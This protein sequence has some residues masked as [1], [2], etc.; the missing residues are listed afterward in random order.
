MTVA[1]E[2]R[3]DITADRT[4]FDATMEGMAQKAMTESQRMQSA[5]RDAF[6]QIGTAAGES[7]KK[8]NS[9]FDSLVEG[10]KKIRGALAAMGALLAGGSMFG[11]AI[12]QTAEL[13]GETRKLSTMLGITLEAASALRIALG[14]IG[15][16]TDDYTG[17]VAKMTMK[18]REN[19]DRFNELG[20]KTRDANG[21]LLNTELITTNALG[22]LK[23]FREGTDRN[24]ASTELFGRGWDGVNKL[25]KLTP[26]VMEEARQKAVSLELQIG[27]AGAERARQYKLA[28]NEIKDVGEALANRIGQALMPV[29]TDLGNWLASMGPAAVTVMRGAL[30]G[31]LTVVYAV[32]NG[33]VVMVRL[34]S[35]ALYTVIEPLAAMAEAAALTLTGHFAEAG[36]RLKQIPQNIS[37]RWKME[38]D[39][40]LKSGDLTRE[41]IAALFD[42]GAEQ[43]ATK[44]GGK[45]GRAY[46]PGAKAGAA[47][48]DAP[49]DKS[50]MGQW[51][52]DLAAQRD[53]YDKQ[54]L[55]QGSFQQFTLAMER[56]Y[57]KN[58][59][60]TVAM[61]DDERAAVSKKY[62][63]AERDLRKMAFDAEIAELKERL[64]RYKQGSI[65]RIRLAG[66]SAAMIG[67]KFGLESRE[68]KQ[69]LGEMS[70][71]AEERGKQQ[72]QLDA[73]MLGRTR[74][75]KVS[76]IELER[77]ALD[78]AEKLGI[79]SNRNK[80]L[81]LK[82]L[83]DIEYQIELQALTDTAALY[84]MDAVAY[85][86]HLDKLA[87]LKGKYALDAQ[88]LDGQVTAESKKTFDALFDPIGNGFQ[89]LM[90]GMIQGTQTW[91]EAIR[92]TLLAVGAEYLSAGVKIAVAWVKTEL[93]KTQATVAGVAVRGAAEK[94][95][96]A[97]SVLVS[98]WTAIK[99]IAIKAWEAAASVY[100]SI[101][102]IPYVGPFLA[103]VMAV[104]AA[105][106][107]LAFVGK[108]ASAEGGFD[109]PRGLSPITQLHPEEMTLPASIANPLRAA[110]EAGNLGVPN[111][112][113]ES[114]IRGIP[115]DEWLMIHRGDLV[116]ALRAAH[117]DFTFTKF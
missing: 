2:F 64:E 91:S 44:P 32:Q 55:E 39:E 101:A 93:L 60:D 19:E 6:T 37:A 105:G 110:I 71:M 77:Q 26:A 65:E 36:A 73:L 34:V 88:K 113:P 104:A 63:T 68:Y 46:T 114:R 107:V 72:Q 56:D 51:D 33:I 40:I 76:V 61:T 15:L 35:A 48:K 28:M 38:F 18:L 81:R 4:Q 1:N 57:W 78:D 106:T 115:P 85:Q 69:A 96:A 21:E 108:I 54:K 16:E 92:K 74:E 80:L 29:M 52:A 13:T 84:E 41:R 116:D 47:E 87:K 89:K 45:G 66:E 90:D 8:V 12:T 82:E 7:F 49:A 97:E 25:M 94:A 109:V 43:G 31:L 20:I 5:M 83:N 24:L 27:P 112:A 53:A 3:T 42:P 10:V 58:I 30:G 67:E 62:Y 95:G 23:N 99:T 102:A 14:D 22:A 75:A 50:R 103:P 111:Q 86:Q 79:I 100:A 98:A 70:K 59:L 17:M 11:K 117:R 9:Q